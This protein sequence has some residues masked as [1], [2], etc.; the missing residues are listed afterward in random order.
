MEGSKKKRASRATT[1]V[2]KSRDIDT[3]TLRNLMT[4]QTDL[5]IIDTRS[6]EEYEKGHIP[7]AYHV[8]Y[9]ELETR[10]KE[11]EDP[12]AHIV[13]IS[14]TGIRSQAVC[15]L[16][17]DRGFKKILNVTGGMSSWTGKREY[18]QPSDSRLAISPSPLLV[19]NIDL[20]PE[21][22]VLDLAMGYGRNA[23]FLAN[24]G[25]EVEGIDNST[26]CV[27]RVRKLAETSE[28]NLTAV[29]ADL[30]KG[31]EIK[32][33]EYDLL[34][35]FYYL[36]RPLFPAII[37]AVKPGGAVVYETLNPEHLLKPNE[38]LQVFSNWRILRYREGIVDERKALEGIVA[39]KTAP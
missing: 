15:R 25:Y 37:Q 4:K 16:L 17:T 22:K 29:C 19:D 8:P 23:L 26:E 2:R 18:G 9:S 12:T 24:R 6:H 3:S 30:E 11:L 38:L 1:S 10:V 7:G 27:K 36:H 20:L 32:E 31:H 14:G 13:V 5:T 28:L 35:C 33:E 21:G 39:V 34:I